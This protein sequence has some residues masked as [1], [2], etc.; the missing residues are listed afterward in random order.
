MSKIEKIKEKYVADADA[1]ASKS[2]FGYFTMLP[3]HTAA[4]TDFSGKLRNILSYLDP[5]DQDGRVVTEPRGI[6]S[7]TT[8]TPSL[9]KNYFKYT[10]SAFHGSEY[11]DPGKN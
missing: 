1:M 4:H 7:G 9:Q 5:R 11:Q 10:P 3:S 2:R 8:S 6:F